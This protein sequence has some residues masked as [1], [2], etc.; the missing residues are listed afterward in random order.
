MNCKFKVVEESGSDPLQMD[1]VTRLVLEHRMVW[2]DLALLTPEIRAD[3]TVKAEAGAKV[4]AAA[5]AAAHKKGESKE[6]KK[7]TGGGQAK[8]KAASAGGKGGGKGGRTAKPISSNRDM[9]DMAAV[10]AVSVAREG[11]SND[12]EQVGG[13]VKS[14][15]A[16]SNVRC[17]AI[18]WGHE[19][20][21]RCDKPR[22]NSAEFSEYH[23]KAS[24]YNRY[25][26][27]K[28][29]EH[30]GQIIY[31]VG[32][33]YR[34]EMAA[35]RKKKTPIEKMVGKQPGVIWLFGECLD[36]GTAVDQPPMFRERFLITDEISDQRLYGI[37]NGQNH[38][39]V[40]RS[41]AWHTPGTPW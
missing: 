34:I 33:A 35:K 21:D 17:C 14:K 3:L 8:S 25:L 38:G 5:R 11:E 7:S 9:A 39:G 6:A 10:D 4:V 22:G 36:D 13:A 16:S 2:C 12:E 19:L 37:R 32:S 20:A 31:G 23:S 40:D 1:D 30:A 27:P 24:Q 29:G 18:T 15:F 28:D 41:E 26:V